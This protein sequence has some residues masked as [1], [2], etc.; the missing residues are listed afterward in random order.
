MT[1]EQA[2]K[3]LDD[4]A[5]TAALSRRDHIAVQQA[6]SLLNDLISPMKP[7]EKTE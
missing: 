6:V 3:I 1:P 4:V 7:A 2:L 5:A